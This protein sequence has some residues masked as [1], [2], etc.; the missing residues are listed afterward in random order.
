MIDRVTVRL[1]AAVATVAIAAGAAS[2]E[3]RILTLE[4]CL[5]MAST[6]PDLISAE[7]DLDAARARVSGSASGWRT[8]ISG[9]DQ[10][11]R[12]EGDDGGHSGSVGLTQRI[13]DS[14]QTRLSVQASREGMMSTEADGIST[15]QGLRYS[16]VEAYCDLLDSL[17]A[18]SIAEEIVEQDVKHLE[19]AKG[20]YDV[21]EKALIDVTQARVNLS[22]AQLDLVKARHAAELARQQLNHSMG[23]PDMEPYEIADLA[24]ERR[25]VETLVEAISTAMAEHPDL[26]SYGHSVAKAKSSLKLAARGLSPTIS[27]T[28]GFSWNGDAPFED[29]EWSVSVKG[30]VPISDGGQTT[31]DTD[32]ARGNLKS[33][34]AKAESER[35]KVELAVRKA[36]LALDE[37]DQSVTVAK[38]T[39]EQAEANLKLANGRY[40]VG[41]GSPTEVADAVTTYGEARLSLSQARYDRETALAALKQAMG[42]M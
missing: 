7:G 13:F 42:R 37:A 8:T 38:E 35:Q 20:F 36:W 27:A 2:A 3:T 34:E 41:E 15:L 25:P 12:S 21:G 11:S 16:I 30:T 19:I 9:S 29:G 24:P 26:K 23:R 22:K 6:H 1:I 40:E 32:E 39:V 5:K 33:A 14:G 10:Y 31:A 4:D 18:R 17:E 28:G